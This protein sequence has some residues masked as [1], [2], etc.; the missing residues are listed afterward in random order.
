MILS[1]Q[2]NTIDILFPLALNHSFRYSW[3]ERNVPPI[4][5]FVRAPIGKRIHTGVVWQGWAVVAP[6]Q[7]I[8]LK[9][10]IERLNLP[11]LRHHH[12]A[13]IEWLARY[14]KT[15]YGQAL[16]LSLNTPKAFVPD[17][18]KILHLN[19]NALTQWLEKSTRQP[20]P[21]QKILIDWMLTVQSSTIEDILN[22]ISVSKHVITNL[23]KH[24][25]FDEIAHPVNEST[26][27]FESNFQPVELNENQKQVLEQIQD[28]LVQQPSKPILLD[29]VT[30]SGKTEVY[31]EMIADALKEQHSQ[32]LIMLPEIALTSQWI[33][34][35]ETRFGA[36]PLIWHSN[37]ST[38]KRTQTWRDI[39]LNKARVV[40]SARSGLFLPFQ[41]LRLIVID[42]E[43]DHAY[44][45]EEGTIYHARDMAVV[46]AKLCNC[47]LL[48]TSATSSFETYM[49][50]QLNRYHKVSLKVRALES[51]PVKVTLVDMREQ[52]RG[53]KAL[54]AQPIINAVNIALRDNKQALLFLNRRGYAPLMLCPGCGYTVECKN[55]S[56]TL[57]FHKRTQRLLCHHCG[58][59]TP[60]IQKCLQVECS[61][62]EY[63]P[64]LIFVGSGV[65]KVEEEA[66]QLWPNARIELVTA[67]SLSSQKMR[68]SF[69]QR[70]EAGEIDLLIGTQ[71]ISKGYDFPSL[72][73]VGILDGDSNL[74]YGDFRAA[75]RC[76]QML[77]QVAGRAGRRQALEGKAFIQTY[78]PHDPLFTDLMEGNYQNFLDRE[79]QKRKNGHW[80]PFTRL[81][82]LLVEGYDMHQVERW[83]H[84]FKKSIPYHDEVQVLGP[85]PAPLEKLHGRWRWRFLF[86]SNINFNLQAWLEQCPLNSKQQSIRVKLDIDPQSFT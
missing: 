2:N 52:P 67:Q 34:R 78:N 3:H 44:K 9:P 48:L 30:G 50:A 70:M 59:T 64:D 8:V 55:C 33:K 23:K 1:M 31:F 11:P 42:E 47:T 43:H 22:N 19:T 15:Q 79:I 14:Y 86:R 45:Q 49:N 74:D 21:A 27:Y 40:I 26:Y 53:K 13:F 58:Y 25:L 54:I 32:V 36:K 29:G 41:N 38:K 7:N 73:V 84:H 12:I 82:A 65:E 68:N 71:I 81:A 66:K 46:Y 4:G 80:P 57:V 61:N 17:V 28:Q 63:P 85:T 24:A 6:L 39:I 35:F 76:W 62:Q 51:K 10:A 20:T 72:S 60:M 69:T 16:K 18:K 77:H 83:C 37:M 5:S 75:E 56:A